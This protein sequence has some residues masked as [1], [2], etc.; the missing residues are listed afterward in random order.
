MDIDELAKSYRQY[1]QARIQIREVGSFGGG[2]TGIFE[3]TIARHLQSESDYVAAELRRR[4][5]EVEGL[6]VISKK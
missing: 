6:R 2:L 5:L 1:V 4:A 3:G